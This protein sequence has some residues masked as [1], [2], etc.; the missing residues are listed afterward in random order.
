MLRDPTSGVCEVPFYEDAP[1]EQL[2]LP[3][4]KSFALDRLRVLR[5]IGVLEERGV[6]GAAFVR[7]SMDLCHEH[8]LSLVGGASEMG[9]MGEAGEAGEAGGEVE[10]KGGLLDPQGAATQAAKKDR[11]SHFILRLACCR[12][13]D[14]RRWF[15][16]RERA[17]F[18]ARLEACDDV[19]WAQVEQ[20][21][22]DN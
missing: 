6:R 10:L 5:G 16:R 3:L 13:D 15:L 17:L 9:E 14:R 21:V 7:A 20:F 2:P 12:S 8:G 18:N 11:A 4:F 1:A 22:G 19:V